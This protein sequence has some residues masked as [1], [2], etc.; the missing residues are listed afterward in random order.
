MNDDG[1]VEALR[2]LVSLPWITQWHFV[3][4][5]Q[6]RRTDQINVFFLFKWQQFCSKFENSLDSG[7]SFTS[8]PARSWYKD[9]AVGTMIQCTVAETGGDWDYGTTERSFNAVSALCVAVDDHANRLQERRQPIRKSDKFVRAYSRT[10]LD[11]KQKTI[12]CFLPS[13]STSGPLFERGL[14]GRGRYLTWQPAV[15]HKTQLP[16][17]QTATVLR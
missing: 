3:G 6:A 14:G 2:S 8:A 12:L 15:K 11:C 13:L 1:E 5:L 10:A 9:N 17:P 4:M 7:Y 16:K